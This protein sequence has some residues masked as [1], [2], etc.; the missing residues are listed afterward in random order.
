MNKFEFGKNTVRLRSKYVINKIISK[1]FLEMLKKTKHNVGN[2]FFNMS[3]VNG[4]K[5]F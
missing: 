3:E 1:R 5:T 4:F 2:R